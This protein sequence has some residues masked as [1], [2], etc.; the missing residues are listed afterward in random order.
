MIGGVMV[1]DGFIYAIGFAGLA[2]T[3]W[4]VIVP[5][6]MARK[7]R[8]RFGSPRYRVWG[9]NKMIALVLVFGVL[10][11]VVHILSSVDLLPVYR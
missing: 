10:N 3:V 1:P 11:A 9:G 4:A 8:K 2:A 5:A 7:S 6:L